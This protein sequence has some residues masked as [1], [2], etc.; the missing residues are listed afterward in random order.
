MKL[1]AD[2]LHTSE[3]LTMDGSHNVDKLSVDNSQN[4]NKLSVD[5]SPNIDKLSVDGSHTT[6]KI[7][8]DGSHYDAVDSEIQPN[9]EI[10]LS[11]Q[12]AIRINDANCETPF[13]ETFTHP[14]NGSYDN[15]AF[16]GMSVDSTGRMSIDSADFG[17]NDNYPLA[18]KSDS[19]AWTLQGSNEKSTSRQAIVSFVVDTEEQQ[20]PK[21]ETRKIN[22]GYV[23]YLHSSLCH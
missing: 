12:N 20:I 13:G 2:D 19:G 17:E 4:I 1:T 9:P 23:I 8:M 5:E 6:E 18:S 10:T 11:N 16:S 3:K 21:K 7:S 15:H 14:E 22:F